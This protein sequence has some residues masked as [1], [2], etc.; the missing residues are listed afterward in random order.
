MVAR[1]KF[2]F[3]CSTQYQL[4][5]ILNFVYNDIE[6]SKKSS[7]LHIVTNKRNKCSF[8]QIRKEILKYDLF[9]EIY[10]IDDLEYNEVAYLRKFNTFRSFMTEILSC[11]KKELH[12]ESDILVIPCATF[13]FEIIANRI[14]PSTIY[15]IDDGIGSYFGNIKLKTMTKSHLFLSRLL[16]KELIVSK[17]YINNKKKCSSTVCREICELPNMDNIDFLGIVEKIFGIHSI[18]IYFTNKFVFLDQPLCE[19]GKGLDE[20]KEAIL[21][22]IQFTVNNNILFRKHPRSK[23]ETAN[24]MLLIDDTM[25]LWEFVNLKYIRNDT[26]LIGIFSTALFTPKLLFDLEPIIVFTFLL[27]PFESKFKSQLLSSAKNLKEGYVDKKKIFIPETEED[28]M[29][30]LSIL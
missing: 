12:N 25:N 14:N 26:V 22:N 9:I 16:R 19:I 1:S 17:L 20:Q 3:A 18:N 28:L 6:S 15:F 21:N 5:N 29:N 27:Y 4:L 24:K 2:T 23:L 13:I 30:I 7:Y 8:E 10:L 11:K